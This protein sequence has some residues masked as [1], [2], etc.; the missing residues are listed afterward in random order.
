MPLIIVEDEAFFKHCLIM[1]MIV[2]VLINWP[3]VSPSLT[4]VWDT[5]QPS[6]ILYIYS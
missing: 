3:N 5:M 1:P 2:K 6:I 4:P